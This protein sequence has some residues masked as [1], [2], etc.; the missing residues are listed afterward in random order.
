MASVQQDKRQYLVAADFYTMA[1]EEGLTVF[2]PYFSN[3]LI[4]HISSYYHWHGY[5]LRLLTCV[6]DKPKIRAQNYG[7]NYDHH[8]WQ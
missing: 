7:Y 1:A 3:M 2:L 8:G 5:F 4:E 6:K